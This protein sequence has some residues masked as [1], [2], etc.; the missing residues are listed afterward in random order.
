MKYKIRIFRLYLKTIQ[1]V[2]NNKFVVLFSLCNVVILLVLSYFL[3]NQPL[4]T[5]ED[6]DQYARMEWL[7]DKLGISKEVDTDDALFINIAYDKQVVD[8]YDDYGM[9][10]GNTD[11]TDRSKLLSFLQL[12]HKTGSYKYIIL[13][14]RFEKGYNVLDVDSA[15]FAEILSMKNI[16]IA[17][18]SDIELADKSLEIKAA[19][20]D[21]FATITKTNFARYQYRQ[22]GK[23]SVPL[24]IY[25]ELTGNTIDKF[26]WFY[27]CNKRLCY[28]SLFVH[29]PIEKWTEYDDQQAKMYYNLGSDV[30][31][32]YS[33][34]D[35]STLTKGKYIVI[36]DMVED[37][38]DTY[39]GL[40]PGS[41]ITYYSL[42]ELIRGRHFVNYG[43]I[44]FMAV[45]FFLISM[46]LFETRSILRRIPFIRNSHSR[47]LHFL[48]DFVEYTLILALSMI[49]IYVLFGIAT[50]I[51]L[52]SAYFAI[53]K[54]IIR[55]KRIKV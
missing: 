19:R 10:I 53:Q 22:E 33:E 41:V 39:S 15:L 13:D 1:I 17:N 42:Q 7:K 28:N 54:T 36:G 52:P 55:F 50:S 4:F 21:Y 31:E 26:G 16:V 25:H 34:N 49:I 12:L 8:K 18:H 27:V 32:N 38:H 20:S 35:I 29:F 47:L 11:I 23:E 48:L 46:S 37:V 14:V 2:K 45:L 30:L 44:L 5:G 6:L 40:K 9:P 51:V 3:N 24:Y 43:M